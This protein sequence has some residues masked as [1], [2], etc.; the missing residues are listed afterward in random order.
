MRINWEKF[1]HLLEWLGVVYFTGFA[2]FGVLSLLVLLPRY[3]TLYRQTGQA[4]ILSRL[5]ESI[6]PLVI[7]FLL[8]SAAAWYQGREIRSLQDLSW[9]DRAI[10]LLLLLTIIVLLTPQLLLA[11]SS[12]L[13]AIKG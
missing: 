10:A 11:F 12:L 8:I 5:E 3:E 2:L 4:G 7:F 1:G 9:Y 6:G 13:P